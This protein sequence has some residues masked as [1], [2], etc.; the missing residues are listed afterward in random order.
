M[1]SGKT[2]LETKMIL[3][4]KYPVLCNYA[5]YQDDEKKICLIKK[6]YKLSWNITQIILLIFLKIHFF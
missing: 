6:K 5:I 1:G 4:A 3:D 2:L